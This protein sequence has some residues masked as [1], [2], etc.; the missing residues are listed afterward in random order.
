M[1][2]A[3]RAFLNTY[4]MFSEQWSQKPWAQLGGL[5]VLAPSPS[6]KTSAL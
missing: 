5:G 3:V 1:A 4:I 2:K 6:F